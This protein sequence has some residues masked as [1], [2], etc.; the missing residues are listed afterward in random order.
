MHGYCMAL[1]CWLFEML[2]FPRGA[3]N[4]FNLDNTLRKVP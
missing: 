3:G 1:C 4:D 2:K